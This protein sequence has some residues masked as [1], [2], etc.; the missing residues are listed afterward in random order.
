MNVAPPIVLTI[1]GF[2]PSAGAGIAADLKTFAAHNCYGVAAIT[3]LTVQSTQGVKAVHA[4]PAAILRA[5]LD[6][7]IKHVNEGLISGLVLGAPEF[8]RR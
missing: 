5:Q 6:D 3:A 4:T 7:P 2:D 8:Q 1:A